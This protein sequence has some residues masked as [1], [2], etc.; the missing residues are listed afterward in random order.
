MNARQR[1]FSFLIC[2]DATGPRL[3]GL[4][5]QQ[6]HE[7]ILEE[8]K[9]RR[10]AVMGELT[11]D[12]VENL[13]ARGMGSLVP[14]FDDAVFPPRE[15]LI[16]YLVDFIAQHR[17]D[18][19][20]SDCQELCAMDE[21][22]WVA[23]MYG[24]D[25]P[26][27]LEIYREVRPLEIL[28]DVN[29]HPDKF[30]Q[31]E[32]KYIKESSIT[33]TLD[34]HGV[35]TTRCK[36]SNSI[37][38]CNLCYDQSIAAEQ[39]V[40]GKRNRA[41]AQRGQPLVVP[42]HYST[43]RRALEKGFWLTFFDDNGD[44]G[45]LRSCRFWE[46][47]AQ[48][49]LAEEFHRNHWWCNILIRP[50]LYT[51]E[52]PSAQLYDFEQEVQQVIREERAPQHIW[53]AIDLTDEAAQ[54]RLMHG[55]RQ[56]VD[57]TFADS[58]P[59]PMTDVICRGRW[60]LEPYTNGSFRGL[61]MSMNVSA[62]D[63]DEGNKRFCT[64]QAVDG[65]WAFE[66]CDVR[67]AGGIAVDV[68][69]APVDKIMPWPCSKHNVSQ[70]ASEVHLDTPE[71]L[72]DLI[73]KTLESCLKAQ[74]MGANP[75]KQ[76]EFK[77]FADA[78]SGATSDDSSSSSFESDGYRGPWPGCAF[79]QAP[80][81]GILTFN[82]SVI[83]GEDDSVDERAIVGLQADERARV[84]LFDCRVEDCY[85]GSSFYDY[86]KGSLDRTLLQRNGCAVV[87]GECATV[88]VEKSTFRDQRL[89]HLSTTAPPD[90]VSIWGVDGGP[91]GCG[92]LTSFEYGVGSI[93]DDDIDADATIRWD[94]TDM[95]LREPRLSLVDNTASDGC[96][97]WFSAQRP[98]TLRGK[99]SVQAA[100][101]Q[102]ARVTCE[103][104]CVEKYGECS[105][106]AHPGRQQDAARS[107]N[108]SLL[109]DDNKFVCQDTN[110]DPRHRDVRLDPVTEHLMAEF[111]EAMMDWERN[112]V[113]R[114][115]EHIAMQAQRAKEEEARRLQQLCHD[116][117]CHVPDSAQSS[118]T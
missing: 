64:V 62:V 87:L 52:H 37:P 69:S 84:S 17:R 18:C 81:A 38:H 117:E 70:L 7:R 41:F 31:I 67:C 97:L 86:A 8:E 2:A 105:N 94:E 61:V 66:C 79:R 57:A 92:T 100:G 75:L 27:L 88:T 91:S 68:T 1:F 90:E 16:S 34:Q 26:K 47:E 40:E 76:D 5:V 113:R 89:A 29:D 54:R 3:D 74:K 19:S 22:E 39:I 4:P 36:V 78:Q 102:C 49:P 51:W 25:Y 85:T 77:A 32:G 55:A 101:C 23:G 12:E 9:L 108:C 28:P 20:D 42:D 63:P 14:D 110:F 72:D 13:R 99:H 21:D 71:E 35:P 43:I 104:D 24:A 33:S 30:W 73:G 11:P 114:Y 59:S 50:G 53:A 83:G 111:P 112:H 45:W 95:A 118:R 58:P 44:R 103:L 98:G 15:D 109:Q 107:G 80:R 115:R 106:V 65:P 60:F 56:N 10:R 82:L 48:R 96:R 116:L 46:H 93:E 6:P